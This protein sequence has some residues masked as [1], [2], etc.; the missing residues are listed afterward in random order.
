MATTLRFTDADR[1]PDGKLLTLDQLLASSRQAIAGPRQAADDLPDPQALPPP[2][3]QAR[4]WLAGSA[5]PTPALIAAVLVAAAT[6]RRRAVVRPC[7]CSNHDADHRPPTTD[8]RSGSNDRSAPYRTIFGI[9]RAGR[10]ALGMI[11]SNARDHADGAL[12]GALDP[13]RRAG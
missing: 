8:R 1:D 5:R 4:S 6:R 11:E 13:G 2:Q 7:A 12:W 3:G 10:A 9:R